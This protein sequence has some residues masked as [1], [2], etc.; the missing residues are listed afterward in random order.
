MGE[1]TL[2]SL[3]TFVFDGPHRRG[4]HTR[5]KDKVKKAKRSDEDA[6][7]SNKNRPDDG[8]RRRVGARR[9]LTDAETDAEAYRTHR[10]ADPWVRG[11]MPSSA[12]KIAATDLVAGTHKGTH[13]A[14]PWDRLDISEPSTSSL[15]KTDIESRVD[16]RQIQRRRLINDAW[17]DCTSL[18]HSYREKGGSSPSTY[19]LMTPASDSSPSSAS[20]STAPSLPDAT[21]SDTT[22]SVPINAS[23][24]ETNALDEIRDSDGDTPGHSVSGSAR[25]ED[26]FDDGHDSDESVGS[27][28]SDSHQHSDDHAEQTSAAS[29]TIDSCAERTNNDATGQD[30]QSPTWSADSDAHYCLHHTADISCIDDPDLDRGHGAHAVLNAFDDDHDSADDDHAR[31]ERHYK[32][33]EATDDDDND[34]DD[35]DFQ[36]AQQVDSDQSVADSAWSTS[37]LYSVYSDAS[38]GGHDDALK[39]IAREALV[40]IRARNRCRLMGND[41]SV[42]ESSDDRDDSA[43]RWDSLSSGTNDDHR[44]RRGCGDDSSESS[45]NDDND[46]DDS[47]TSSS[48]GD[49]YD[50]CHDDRFAAHD[51]IIVESHSVTIV[52]PLLRPCEPNAP[53]AIF[54]RPSCEQRRRCKKNRPCPSAPVVVAPGVADLPGGPPESF[55]ALGAVYTLL[56]GIVDTRCRIESALVAMPPRARAQPTLAFDCL[57][58]NVIGVSGGNGAT[59]IINERAYPLAPASSFYIRAGSTFAVANCG[60]AIP[61]VFVQQ[62][63]GEAGGLGF[64]RDVAT[65]EAAVGGAANADAYVVRAIAS[66]YGARL[67]PIDRLW[68]RASAHKDFVAPGV[69]RF[70]P[71][72]LCKV[73]VADHTSSDVSSSP[74]ACTDGTVSW[75][76]DSD[77]SATA[78]TSHRYFDDNNSDNTHDGASDPS[79]TLCEPVDVG[80]DSWGLLRGQLLVLA[81]AGNAGPATA[82]GHAAAT[83][84]PADSEGLIALGPCAPRVTVRAIVLR[85]PRPDGCVD[86]LAR[87]TINGADTITLVTGVSYWTYYDDKADNVI[88]QCVPGSHLPAI[89]PP[90]F[91]TPPLGTLSALGQRAAPSNIIP[92]PPISAGTVPFV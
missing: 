14:N 71:T 6:V 65:Y 75:A 10:E 22:Q 79:A 53:H 44:H 35:N 49:D 64:Y 42:S 8:G 18:A 63:V 74:S 34:D 11:P 43:T 80:L 26:S 60:G 40:C 58:V 20:E 30:T 36:R 12:S 21:S 76:D 45:H 81:A 82:A 91:G 66:C 72:P 31:Y 78:T 25:A 9:R 13:R 56:A 16:H 29:T 33:S 5:Q 62:F 89:L 4:A 19:S 27:S 39:V 83:L 23:D 70:L 46:D 88:V 3:P 67:G 48:S 2:S 87:P 69:V 38:K 68:R 51:K 7:K 24:P 86:V 50:E 37:A 52:E 77:Q 28:A 47:I 85:D 90:A 92:L 54:G 17:S 55:S 15:S 84:R 1:P 61:L 32:D 57:D 59:I 73:V 41:E